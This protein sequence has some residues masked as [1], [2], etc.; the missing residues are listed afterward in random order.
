MCYV[1]SALGCGPAV[2][3]GVG[4][5]QGWWNV[6][7]GQLPGWDMLLSGGH[8][9]I[10]T[11]LSSPSGEI[12]LIGFAVCLLG[13]FYYWAKASAKLGTWIWF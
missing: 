9:S 8:F 6:G 10:E 5:G 7:G 3:L 1:F 11:F 13:T 4:L 12:V 2:V